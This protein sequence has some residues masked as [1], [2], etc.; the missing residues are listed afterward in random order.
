MVNAGHPT[1]CTCEVLN[2][3][4]SDAYLAS[5]NGLQ[6]YL[7]GCFHRFCL[8][9]ISSWTE[10]QRR[11][12]PSGAAPRFVCPL[13]KT[14]YASVLHDYRHNAYRCA[15][16]HLLPV[17]GVSLRWSIRHRGACCTAESATVCAMDVH[18]C[19]FHQRWLFRCTVRSRPVCLLALR[20]RKW[21]AQHGSV[22]GS[23]PDGAAVELTPLQ[24][25]RRA[26]YFSPC[27]WFSC[28]P[29]T[30]QHISTATGSR[31]VGCRGPH[32]VL[33]SK[34]VQR[35]LLSAL[36]LPLL[37]AHRSDACAA[38]TQRHMGERQQRRKWSSHAHDGARRTVRSRSVAPAGT[39]G[40]HA[41]E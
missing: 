40:A 25:R 24:R 19:G 14:P 11:H 36:Q 37:P 39:G 15:Q 10:S 41:G 9:C 6:A 12:P 8:A 29:A 17:D 30:F 33:P 1:Y 26:S 23:L 13:C 38:C 18:S 34:H 3:Q 32:A 22:A 4:A 16:L 28:S 27:R 5:L 7:D 21:V 35:V 2:S 31:D 20:R